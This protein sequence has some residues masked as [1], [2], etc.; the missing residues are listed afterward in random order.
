MDDLGDFF[1]LIGGE[2]K[3]EKEKTKEIMGEVSLGDLFT[4][5]NE[6]KKRVKQKLIEKEEKRKKDAQI[7]EN[8]RILNKLSKKTRI[9]LTFAEANGLARRLAVVTR[10]ASEG[11]MIL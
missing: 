10:Y 8:I 7:F 5:L 11:I 4:S 1:S 2:K 3:K 9:L 6:E